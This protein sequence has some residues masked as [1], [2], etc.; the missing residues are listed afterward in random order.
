MPGS[1]RDTGRGAP[2]GLAGLL[3]SGL[4]T[5]LGT[6]LMASPWFARR[7]VLDRWFLHTEQ[8][9]LFLG[10]PRRHAAA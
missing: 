7:V 5:W 6:R 10:E 2:A 8:P 9:A 3:P 4:V 1:S